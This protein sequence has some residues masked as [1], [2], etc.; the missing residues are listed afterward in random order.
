MDRN[1]VGVVLL[2]DEDPYDVAGKWLAWLTIMILF[3]VILVW[4][5]RYFEPKECDFSSM[6]DRGR[7]INR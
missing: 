5:T 3:V 7:H 4:F 2:K 6:Y 1:T